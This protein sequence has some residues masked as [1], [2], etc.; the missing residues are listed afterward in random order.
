[1]NNLGLTSRVQVTFFTSLQAPLTRSVSDSYKAKIKVIFYHQRYTRWNMFTEITGNEIHKAVSS[2]RRRIAQELTGARC[3]E[4]K[5]P[6]GDKREGIKYERQTDYGLLTVVVVPEEAE[7]TRYIHGVDVDRPEAHDSTLRL[8]TSKAS[9]GR[10]RASTVFAHRET[11]NSI[12]LCHR[13]FITMHRKRLP[14]AEIIDYF[15]RQYG[16]IVDINANG[17]SYKAI[18]I[19]DLESPMLFDEIAR[20]AK[21]MEEFKAHKRSY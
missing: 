7:P 13:G 17:K 18:K 16:S 2:F 10:A 14:A 19:D 15:G 5:H 3:S 4:F 11:T 21:Q 1:M 8:S 12:Y 6:G 9:G 20:F